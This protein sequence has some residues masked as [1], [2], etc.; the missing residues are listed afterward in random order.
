MTPFIIGFSTVTLAAFCCRYGRRHYKNEHVF[1]VLSFVIL[2]ALMGFKHTSLGTDSVMYNNIF[3]RIGQ[4]GSLQNAIQAS[5]ISAPGYV[6]FC[7]IIYRI[8]PY[9]EARNIITSLIVLLGIYRYIKKSS[10]DVY[11]SVLLYISLTFYVQGFNISR[12]HMAMAI[13]LNSFVEWYANKKSILGWLLFAIAISIHTTAIV[14]I[15]AWI[16]IGNNIDY[17]DNKQIRKLVIKALILGSVVI[18]SQTQLIDAFIRLFPLYRNYF[19]ERALNQFADQGQ[20]RTII[21][22]IGYLVVVIYCILLLKKKNNTNNKRLATEQLPLMLFSVII[23][24]LGSSYPTILRM[25]IFFTITAITYIPNTFAIDKP[26]NKRILS[27]ITLVLTFTFLLLYML[28]DKSDVIPY[29]FFW[30][31]I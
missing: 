31:S 10:S 16:L 13:M 11:L 15:A 12:Q 19:G 30:N 22:I 14:G 7:R 18:L 23:G 20:G 21:I 17:N 26:S 1:I 24:I 25:N 6:F 8:L 5:G 9:N 4:A 3:M 28:E 2:F 29:T 27:M